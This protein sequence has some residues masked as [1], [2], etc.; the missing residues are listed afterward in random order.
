VATLPRLPVPVEHRILKT[1]CALPPKVQRALFG[2]PPQLDGQ[3][4]ATDIH[5]MITLCHRSGNYS[6]TEGR[7]PEEARRVNRHDAAVARARKPIPMSV[8]ED[9]EIPGP[10]GPIPLRRYLPQGAAAGVPLPL[11]LFSHGGGWVIGDLDTHDGVCRFLAAVAG[12]QVVAVDYRL[13]PEHPFP[14]PLEDVWAAYGWALENAAELGSDP[15]RIAVGGDS[16]GGNMAGVTCLLARE[17]G[18][19]LPA[20]QLLIYPVT[21]PADEMPSRRTFAKGFM[22]TKG[23]IDY[24]DSMYLPPHV[25]RDDPRISVF[26]TGDLS[27]MPPAYLA[28]AGFDPLRDEGEAFGI[29]LREA[30]VPVAMKRYPGLVHGFANETPVCPTA[31]AAMLELAGAL[32][33][34]LA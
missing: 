11:L 33:M 3:T 25:D 26:K 29:R 21:D 5:T 18:A 8:V 22:L 7:P 10:G 23:D 14:E 20:M 12:V 34:G 9:F 13:S 28:T 19:P 2:R 24:F 15:R 17:A 31:R 6:F 16:A 4:L 30:G 27:G 32:R 1:S